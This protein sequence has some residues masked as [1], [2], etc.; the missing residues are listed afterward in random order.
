MRKK[1]TINSF[2]E[3]VSTFDR[4]FLSASLFK[5]DAIAT[6][7]V[8]AIKNSKIQKNS[9]LLNE[10]INSNKYF[11]HK[12]ADLR[13]RGLISQ[14]MF[15][16]DSN[17]IKPL[18]TNYKEAA[19]NILNHNPYKLLL[20]T[21]DEHEAYD[22]LNLMYE[23]SHIK[24]IKAC[25]FDI[26]GNTFEFIEELDY[27][28]EVDFEEAP[29][30]VIDE[31]FDVVSIDANSNLPYRGGQKIPAEF[32]KDEVIS[33][34]LPT[35]GSTIM[36][37]NNEPIVIGSK[38]GDGGEG[39]VYKTDREGV[40]VK[41]I[42]LEGNHLSKN[43]QKKLEQ[44]VQIKINH[45]LVVW[46]QDTVYT[47]DGKFVGFTMQEVSGIDLKSF[48]FHKM[49]NAVLRPGEINI[50]F[51]NK[52][53][54]CG[55]ILNIL[56]TIIYLHSRNIVIGDIKLEN[57]MIKDQDISKIYFVDCDSYQVGDF[58]SIL[59]SPGFKPPEIDPLITGKIAER[60]RTFGNEN[61]AIFSLLFHLIFRAKSP[62]TQQNHTG[63]DIADWERAKHGEFPYFLDKE[64][65]LASAPRGT[66]EPIWAHLPGYIKKAFI[67]VG[68]YN[69]N[70]FGEKRRL[71]AKAW[72]KIFTCYLEDL[73][74][75]KLESVDPKCHQY[76][77]I[78]ERDTMPYTQVEITMSREEVV[79]RTGF[80][81]D[82]TVK[83]LFAASDKTIPPTLIISVV[84]ALKQSTRY[85]DNQ[86]EFLLKK[87][88]GM[89][90]DIE[91]I[92]VK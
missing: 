86:F 6:K 69:G 42:H 88:A 84:N 55:I 19:R 64:K 12:A 85:K 91:F 72:Q 4:V 25:G 21:E 52:I 1:Q 75:G 17:D 16:P 34:V 30:D 73:L 9:I 56:D 61:F 76:H 43:K 20:I 47:T 40:V 11:L 18:L 78:G 77:F 71:D 39:T 49:P 62:Y 83:E 5:N 28:L 24:D 80:S 37:K 87:H 31:S 53:E 36:T 66:E 38:L 14:R 54:L 2:N 68:H 51:I 15:Q 79:T 48:T 3:Y 22:Y 41:I 65:T 82:A 8:T 59:V 63:K 44:M 46:P 74:S 27:I 26:T 60:F 35:E 33:V 58:P 45:D 70:N 29:E 13:S 90:Y 81:I 89:F 92:Y 7:V 23:E 50:N 57:F 10:E 32:F 67:N